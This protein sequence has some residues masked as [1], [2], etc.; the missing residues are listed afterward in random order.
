MSSI[1]ALAERGPLPELRTGR[2]SLTSLSFLRAGAVVAGVPMMHPQVLLPFLA[3]PVLM[4]LL[5]VPPGLFV[6]SHWQL[7]K[8]KKR[9][10]LAALELHQWA[11]K[12][13]PPGELL[14]ETQILLARAERARKVR[15]VQSVEAALA[16]LVERIARA[17]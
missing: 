14:E 11:E 6:W 3:H 2:V 12:H 8:R 16:Y 1:T 17:L 10:K 13:L 9:A 5:L 7:G 4:P 15:E